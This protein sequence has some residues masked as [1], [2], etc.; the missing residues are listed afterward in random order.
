MEECL[1]IFVCVLISITVYSKKKKNYLNAFEKFTT[2]L[3]ALEQNLGGS[4]SV[5]F[6]LA[7]PL[8]NILV[9]TL[10]I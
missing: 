9:T 2:K 8:Y 1:D 7:P 10:F 6:N 5:A 3:S 4:I